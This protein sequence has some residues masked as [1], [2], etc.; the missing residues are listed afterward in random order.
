MME[1][2]KRKLELIEGRGGNG[3]LPTFEVAEIFY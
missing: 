1:E 2:M 3:C